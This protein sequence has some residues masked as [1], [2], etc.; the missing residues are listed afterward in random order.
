MEGNDM[1]RTLIKKTIAVTGLLVMVAVCLMSAS[2]QAAGDWTVNAAG[3]GDF[4][5][6]QEALDSASVLDGDTINV[7]AASYLSVDAIDVNKEVSIV[8]SGAGQT[9]IRRN[10]DGVSRY[11]SVFD[12][13]A[14]NVTISNMTVGGTNIYTEDGGVMTDSK[15]YVIG[16]SSGWTSA[17]NL[18]VS[19]VH[20][21]GGRS[22]VLAAGDNFTMTNSKVTGRWM[23][24][25]VRLD[26]ENFDVS[27]N[28]FEGLHYQY[29]PV[30]LSESAPV[31]GT[32]SYNYMANGANPGY[33]KSSGNVFTI[34]AYNEN[35]AEG[36]IVI[37]HNTIDASKNFTTNV[38]AGGDGLTR[39][40]IYGEL[41][42][43]PDGGTWNPDE[44]VV[45]DNIIYGFTHDS[46]VTSD[47]G[48]G[49][50]VYANTDSIDY[51]E[52]DNNLFFAN[53]SDA[54]VWYK[55]TNDE[56]VSVTGTGQNPVSGD[57][58]FAATGSELEDYFALWVGSPALN[59]ASDGTHVGAYQGEPVPEPATM[60]LLGLGGLV[61]AGRKKRA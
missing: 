36:G 55:D 6:I 1:M 43:T 46:A 31:S 8:G 49:L 30:Y 52:I 21:D 26:G 13:T 20:F 44:I 23:R 28:S 7:T 59:A 22:A 2:V 17:D 48:A 40:A 29:G 60:G 38:K 9:I 54:T 10:F 45:R 47:E 12:V 34:E 27:H 14:D 5:T 32:I 24:A 56:W 25:S 37:S 19:G 42:E 4:L 51:V 35:I 16:H 18:T 11:A 39:W 15:G 41:F 50:Y 3:G 33:F 58:L 61:L 53:D 57:P